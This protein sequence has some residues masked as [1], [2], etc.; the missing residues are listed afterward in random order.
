MDLASPLEG[1][2]KPFQKHMPTYQVEISESCFVWVAPT[3]LRGGPYL[4]IEE[5]PFSTFT[6]GADSNL[7]RVLAREVWHDWKY[8]FSMNIRNRWISL[9]VETDVLPVQINTALNQEGVELPFD[10]SYW[11]EVTTNP[12]GKHY[13]TS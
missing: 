5:Q 3:L 2:Y 11:F 10:Q 8:L 1:E 7:A 13:I 4:K 9:S 6:R 12:L